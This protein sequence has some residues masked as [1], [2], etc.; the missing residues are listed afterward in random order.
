MLDGLAAETLARL[1]FAVSASLPITFPTV[2]FAVAGDMPAPGDS[3][4]GKLV[5]AGGLPDAAE[6]EER[7]SA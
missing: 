1:Q 3:V 7:L 2:S 4:D 5:H 6:L